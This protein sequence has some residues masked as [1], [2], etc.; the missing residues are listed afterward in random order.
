MLKAFPKIFFWFLLGRHHSFFPSLIELYEIVVEQ[1]DIEQLVDAG[2]SPLYIVDLEE[3]VDDEGDLSSCQ[4][5]SPELFSSILG[6][7]SS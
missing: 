4:H 3:C 5:R 2:G 7:S 1:L 6:S